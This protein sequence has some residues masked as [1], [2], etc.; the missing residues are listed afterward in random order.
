V[1]RY[2]GVT[3]SMSMEDRGDGREAAQ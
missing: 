3:R 2:A 1:S